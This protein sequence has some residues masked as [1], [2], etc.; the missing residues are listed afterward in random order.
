[1]ITIHGGEKFGPPILECSFGVSRSSG[2]DTTRHTVCFN[3]GSLGLPEAVLTAGTN[4]GIG[5][6]NTLI[7]VDI[8]ASL[9]D[10]HL[11]SLLVASKR[12]NSLFNH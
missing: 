11:P 5:C 9:K 10:A 6:P 12:F 3:L 4:I 1:V 7:P 8:R 2:L